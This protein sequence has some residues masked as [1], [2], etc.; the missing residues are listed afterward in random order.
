MHRDDDLVRLD[1]AEVVE[2]MGGLLGPPQQV[3]RK[4]VECLAGFGE[5]G[6][7]AALA[8]E[9]RLPDLV[10]ERADMG[11]DRGLGD[12]ELRGRSVEAAEIDDILEDAEAAR[13]GGNH[14]T[15][16]GYL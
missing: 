10:F 12:A 8:V 7:A 4:C 6:P 13:A 3:D 16:H 1:L 5:L 11:A 2:R 14:G 15:G 9:Q